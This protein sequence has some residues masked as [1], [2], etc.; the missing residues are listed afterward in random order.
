MTVNPMFLSVFEPC[1]KIIDSI[2]FYKACVYDINHLHIHHIGCTSIET[3]ADACAEARVCID[4]RSET[5]G[6]CGM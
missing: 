3:Y 1:H 5:K 2:P 6:V 4:W